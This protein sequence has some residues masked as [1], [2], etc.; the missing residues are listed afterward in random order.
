M[1]LCCLPSCQLEGIYTCSRCNSVG[2]CSE[3]H[4]R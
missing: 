1:K 3:E 2:Y 4:Q